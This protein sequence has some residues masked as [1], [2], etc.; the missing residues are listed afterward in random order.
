MKENQYLNLAYSYFLVLYF[1]LGTEHIPIF[2]YLNVSSLA[3]L[4]NL[5]SLIDNYRG[6][7]IPNKDKAMQ[8]LHTIFNPSF[9]HCLRA[10]E[11]CKYMNLIHNLQNKDSHQIFSNYTSSSSWNIHYLTK[12]I[13]SFEKNNGKWTF[14]L[15]LS[16]QPYRRKE[17]IGANFSG[18]WRKSVIE[19]SDPWNRKRVEKR[20]LNG[21]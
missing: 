1:F 21:T 3:Y 10:I 20:W 16:F 14:N 9:L 6:S 12:N 7:G 19:H 2:L 15:Y 13:Q 18:E 17:I 5:W 8:H 11:I 4:E